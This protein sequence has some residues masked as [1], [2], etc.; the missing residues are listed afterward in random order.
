[1]LASFP[2]LPTALLILWSL[3]DPLHAQEEPSGGYL[4]AVFKGDVP[5]VFFN[6]APASTP[7]TFTP[8]NNGEAVLMP[9]SGTGGARDPFI[10]KAQDSSGVRKARNPFQEGVLTS[11]VASSLS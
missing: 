2:S 3:V 4:A 7:S 9:T 1:M 11:L 10:F 8:L 6:L 5:H